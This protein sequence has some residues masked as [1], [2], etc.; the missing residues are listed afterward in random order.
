[1][2][3]V[4]ALIKPGC[5]QSFGVWHAPEVVP[6]RSDTLRL[7]P[8]LVCL[9]AIACSRSNIGL[10]GLIAQLRHSH[11]SAVSLYGCSLVQYTKH[12]L[13]FLRTNLAVVHQAL[14]LAGVWALPM[15]AASASNAILC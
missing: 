15:V 1:V 8:Q 14:V 11:T 3:P 5:H 10:E 9:Q 4:N 12:V 6:R 7:L 2:K 13:C